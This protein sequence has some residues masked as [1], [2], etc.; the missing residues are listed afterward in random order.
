MKKTAKKSTMVEPE[1]AAA[2]QAFSGLPLFFKRPAALD[3]ERHANAGLSSKIDLSF[4]KESNSV[5]LNAIEFIEASHYYPIVFTNEEAP[6]P[7]AVLG[8]D[9]H[10]PFI[11][12]TNT[13]RENTYIPAYVRQYPFVLFQAPNSDKLY[14][15][16][17]EAASGYIETLSDEKDA[18]A[19]YTDGKP[20]AATNRALEFANAFYQHV[21]ITRNFCDDLKKHNL[22]AP[23]NSTVKIDGNEKHLNGFLMIDETAFNALPQDVFLEFRTKG[24]LPF[25]YL[26]LASAANWKRL[27]EVTRTSA[28]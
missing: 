4:A 24:W 3:S 8:W 27:M 6:V 9:P 5:P 28:A 23:Y 11:T 12:A 25:I 16:V 26:S 20:T 13:W 21:K 10:N 14:L 18:M 19:L 7:V 17:D 15:C 1:S 2:E 22:L